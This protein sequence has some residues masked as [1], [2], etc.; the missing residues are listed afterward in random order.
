MTLLQVRDLT[1]GFPTDAATVNAVRGMNFDVNKGE[2]VALVGESGAGKSATAMAVVGLLPEYAEVSGSIRLHDTE[3]V[4]LSDQQMSTIR[5]KSIGMVFQDP[6]SALTPVYTVGDQIA[7]ALRIHQRDIGKQ[8]ARRRAVELLELVGINQPERRARSFPHELSGGER[9]RVVIAIAI[10]N[11]PDLLICD[12]PTTALDV[13][14][15]AQILEVLRTARDV[16]GAG[17]LIIT[18]DLGVVAEFADR[19]L[20][21]YAGRAVEVAPVDQL[22]RDRRMP[23]TVG[24]LGS[25]PRLDAAQGTRLVPI[26]GAPPSMAAL[27]PG[28][29]FAPRCPLAVDECRS[30]EPDL[31]PM[32]PGHSAACIRT[33]QVVGRSAADIYGVSTAAPDAAPDPDAPVVLRVRDLVKT[34]KL[35]KGVVFRR[36]VGEVRAVDGISFDLQQGRTLGIVGES[37][38]GKSTTLHQILALTAPQSG[39]IEVLGTDVATLDRQ[40][41]RALRGDL[42]VVFQDPVAS[43]DPRLPVFEVLA[44]PLQANGFDKGRRDD[45]VAELLELVGL[46]REDASR[47]PAEFSGGQKQRIGIA[48]ALAL[49]PKILALDEP[50]SALDVSIQAGIINLLLDLQQRFGLSYL[51]VSHDLSVVRHL[52]HR[53]VVMHKGTVVEQGDADQVFGDPQH[54][55][56]RRLL[57]AVPQPEVQRS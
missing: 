13:T 5:G 9:Q 30:A 27:P 51:F 54:D 53:V 11:D 57:A 50:V 19:A 36:Q 48:R 49:Q 34:Y 18:H 26:P 56:T 44:E 12:E 3:L 21:M 38:S 52:A 8:A 29:P 17:V 25:V 42:Q 22:Y 47:Y 6:M 41:R 7:E 10:A 33:D 45:R 43:L 55:Y 39:S 16:T 46:R 37:G 40:A 32:G 2:V 28:C 31:L 24:L 35:T 15:Q 20:V 23:Y 14:V 1:V 4:G